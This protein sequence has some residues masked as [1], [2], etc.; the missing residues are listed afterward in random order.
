[1]DWNCI[2]LREEEVMEVGLVLDFIINNL[3][4]SK[5]SVFNVTE[6]VKQTSQ[7]QVKVRI[8][9]YDY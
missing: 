9:S 3:N 2:A 6:K 1:M 4:V 7:F 5:F 8:L